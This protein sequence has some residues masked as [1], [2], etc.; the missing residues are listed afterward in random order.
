MPDVYEIAHGLDPLDESDATS[1]LDGDGLSNIDEYNLGTLASI[2]DSDG[3][4]TNDGDEVSAGG[5]PL[6]ANYTLSPSE[7]LFGTTSGQKV[8]RI[9]NPDSSSVTMPVAT[10]EGAHADQFTILSDACS[11]MTLAQN[12]GCDITVAYPASIDTSLSAYLNVNNVTAF[13]HNYEAIDEEAAR[14]LPPVIDN[15]EILENMSVGTDYNLTWSI[16]GYEDDYTA[17]IALFN[18]NESAVAGTCGESYGSVE[19]ID[20]GLSLRPTLTEPA[21]WSYEGKVATKF[22]YSYTFT[23]QDVDFTSGDTPIVIRFYYASG[24]DVTAGD[25]SISLI[26]PGNLSAE[27]YD[28]SGR[29]IQK[30]VTKP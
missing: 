27:Y 13:M 15:I 10:L 18:C 22:H 4:G 1:D 19:R 9:V 23:P 17:Y 24:S 25:S 6:T 20:E 3:D 7:F 8:F 29:K 21:G 28:T 5:D 2:A 26:I 12:E 30:I 14:R 16:V 11:G